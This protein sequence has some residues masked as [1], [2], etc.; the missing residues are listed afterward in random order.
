MTFRR[1]SIA[2][3]AAKTPRMDSIGIGLSMSATIVQEQGGTISAGNR[4]STGS[5][6]TI[7]F[8]K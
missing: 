8:P 6:F 5:E 4:I 2:F 7:R 1:Y 3:T